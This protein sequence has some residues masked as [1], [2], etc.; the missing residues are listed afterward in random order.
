MKWIV[1]NSSP[2]FMKQQFYIIHLYTLLGI[3]S[4]REGF[5]GKLPVQVK[6]CMKHIV[7]IHQHPADKGRGR[8][9][10]T[11]SVW[12]DLPALAI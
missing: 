12:T 1:L 6:V 5:S 10:G 2:A 4:D 11:D 9:Q 8:H 3:N 7:V